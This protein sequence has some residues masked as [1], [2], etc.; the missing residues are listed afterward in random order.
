MGVQL[1]AGRSG[2][3]DF[4]AFQINRGDAVTSE[5]RRVTLDDLSTGEIVVR[6][7]FAGVNYKDALATSEYGNVIR[8]FPR[9]M[10]GHIEQDRQPCS[11]RR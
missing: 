6:T 5:L 3:R 11:F 7:A 8:R 2:E 4:T 1:I 9:R 10:K